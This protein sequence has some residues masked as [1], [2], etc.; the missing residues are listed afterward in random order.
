MNNKGIDDRAV[1]I[2]GTVMHLK[3]PESIKQDTSATITLNFTTPI[4]KKGGFRS[5][6]VDS[7]SFFMAYV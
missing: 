3:L 6:T 1:R 4:P 2:S 5:G 7:S